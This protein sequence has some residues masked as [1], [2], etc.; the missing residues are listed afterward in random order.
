MATDIVDRK[1]HDW[2][3][4]K[5]AKDARISIFYKIRDIPYA[6]IPEL[7]DPERYVDILKFNRGSCTPKHFLLCYMYQ[8]IGLEVLYVVY[9]FRWNDFE[10]VYPPELQRLAD[11]M[12]ISY[13]LACK[14]DIDGKLVLVDA[15]ID[16][17][18]QKIG[19]PVNK[20]WDG[21]S[22]TLLAVNPCGEEQLYHPSEI[23]FMQPPTADEQSLAFYNRLNVW[24]KDTRG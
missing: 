5:N 1:L 11:A 18:L 15:T 19:L 6:V 24:L 4:G 3:R 7:N 20:K 22:D 14:V 10:A 9:P 8:K 16:P 13:H 21:L 17:A 12:P 23:H 2:T